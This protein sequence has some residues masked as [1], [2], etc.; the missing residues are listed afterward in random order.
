MSFDPS[1]EFVNTSVSPLDSSY[2][3]H[4]EDVD[5]DVKARQDAM[6]IARGMCIVFMIAQHTVSYWG[7]SDI[8]GTGYFKW[9]TTGPGDVAV[10]FMFIMGINSANFSRQS[11]KQMAKR[12]VKFLI[13]GYIVNL[14]RDQIPLMLACH[15]RGLC[16]TDFGSVFMFRGEYDNVFLVDIFQFAGG[17]MIFLSL[18]RAHGLSINGHLSISLL[19][20]LALACIETDSDF[21]GFVGYYV[22]G[23]FYLNFFPFRNWL[24]FPVTGLVMGHYWRPY[25]LFTKDSFP[26]KK[27]TVVAV[28]LFGLLFTG[29]FVYPEVLDHYGFHNYKGYYNQ[30]LLTNLFFV[31]QNILV[32]E[33]LRLLVRRHLIADWFFKFIKFWSRNIVAIYLV[34]WITIGFA[35]FLI[36]GVD[37]RINSVPLLF[38]AMV[39]VMLTSD[40]IV[41][42]INPISKTLKKMLK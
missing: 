19:F 40:L 15:F 31:C 13:F 4:H 12:G 32:L 24:I 1:S 2:T 29:M 22:I 39:F 34:S 33:V 9:T 37:N 26:M 27:V 38:S 8:Q 28:V 17:A 11:A 5:V 6:D 21:T 16:Y 36:C 35:S 7:H 10:M 23:T 42:F 30:N 3:F 41:R 18:L 20:I 25:G 14:L